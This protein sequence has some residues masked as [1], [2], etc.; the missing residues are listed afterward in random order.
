MN[1]ADEKEEEH[2][3]FDWFFCRK[4]RDAVNLYFINWYGHG[5]ELDPVIFFHFLH[6]Q[7]THLKPET[8]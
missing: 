1:S 6:L 2:L 3:S 5:Y 8:F 7:P 4:C